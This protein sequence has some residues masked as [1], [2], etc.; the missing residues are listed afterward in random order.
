[1]GV[2]EQERLS[3]A[4]F[5]KA[6]SG[7]DGQFELIDGVAYAMAGAKQGH[8][9]ISSNVQTAFVPAGKRQGCR[10]TSSDTGVLTGPRSVRFPD[11]V[12]DCGPADPSALTATA[13][14][15]IVE[16]SSPGTAVFDYGE[17]LDE[18][19]GL[20]SVQLILQI[21]SEIVLVK[22]HRRESEGWKETMH[23]S[24]ADIIE[25]APLRMSLSVA[26]IYDTLAVSPRARLQ[27]VR[28]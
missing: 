13:P 28:T 5:F 3:V 24:L 14:T 4:T 1:M 20:A 6:I 16:V 25:I 23:E 9:V 2:P 21:E 17:K 19:R 12:V 18:Y 10:T 7:R 8:N 27:V 26:E 22:A 11:V 15:V